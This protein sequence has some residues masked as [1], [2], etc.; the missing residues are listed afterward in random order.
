MYQQKYSSVENELAGIKKQIERCSKKEKILKND[1]EELN[2]NRIIKRQDEIN[3]EKNE[4]LDEIRQLTR[5]SNLFE[6]IIEKFIPQSTK[7]LIYLD[8]VE[9]ILKN[10]Q[11]SPNGEYELPLFNLKEIRV[12]KLI[13]YSQ[14]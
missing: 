7:N 12:W 11:K 9:Y 1:Y 6:L 14:K 13:R 8:E 4:R 10:I 5:D 2:V 3:R